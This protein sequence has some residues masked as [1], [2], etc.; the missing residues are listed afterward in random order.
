[1]TTTTLIEKI[2]IVFLVY[3]S[4]TILIQQDRRSSGTKKAV[5]NSNLGFDSC[6]NSSSIILILPVEES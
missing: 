1:M 3:V 5:E 4:L 2:I 6:S